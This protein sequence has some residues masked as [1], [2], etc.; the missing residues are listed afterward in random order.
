MA[1]P[2]ACLISMHPDSSTEDTDDICLTKEQLRIIICGVA[3]F[4][5]EREEIAE[6]RGPYLKLL[7]FFDISKGETR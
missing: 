4:Q 3:G 6:I 1:Q 2:Y 5:L 7:K